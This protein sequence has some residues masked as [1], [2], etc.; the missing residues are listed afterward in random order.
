MRM[1]PSMTIMTIV[2]M[3]VMRKMILKMRRMMIMR[4]SMKKSRCFCSSKLRMSSCSQV[5]R[6]MKAMMD[7]CWLEKELQVSHPLTR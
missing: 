6:M 1:A 5:V 3:Q 4:S 2:E 7:L